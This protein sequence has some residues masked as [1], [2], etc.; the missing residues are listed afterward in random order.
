MWRCL[1]LAVSLLILMPS[2]ESVL[3]A[4]T[5]QAVIN[6]PQGPVTRLAS[7]DGKWTLVFECPND[8]AERKLWIEASSSHTR[9]LV[10]EYDRSLGISWAPDSHSFF[11]NDEYGSNGALCYVIDPLDLKVK[12]IATL[13]TSGDSDAIMFLKAGHSYL[14]AKRWISSRELLVVLYGH[15]DDPPSRGFTIR[16][17]VGLMGSVKKLS[18]RGEEEP[19]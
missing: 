11:V 9:R 2:T 17:Q 5:A 13:I 14:K 1:V 10:K 8:C 7:P 18:Q 16:Y 4:S 19:Q 3:D 15:F 12:D 6:L